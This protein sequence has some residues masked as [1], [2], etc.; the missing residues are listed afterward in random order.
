MKIEP[1]SDCPTCGFGLTWSNHL[2]YCKNPK[3]SAQ[4][5][6]KLEH[7]AKTLKIK[8]LGP[9]TI[10]KLNLYDLYDLYSLTIKSLTES[11]GSEKVATKLFNEIEHSK[12]ATANTL[13]AGFSIP[14]IGKTA[15][16]K[17]STICDTIFD[18]S[19]DN[20]KLAGLGPKATANLL[21]W[22]QSEFSWYC[23]LPFSWEFRKPIFDNKATRGNVCITGKLS[24]YKTKAEAGE[25]LCRHG[26]KVITSVSSGCTHLVNESG[27]ESAKTKKARE[28]GIEIISNLTDFLG[29]NYG[30]S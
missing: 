21:A 4:V 10:S 24:S 18:I 9:A 20:C 11:L 5:D 14:L 16:E 19:E 6:K 28:N 26:F 27:I 23:D 15:S 25:A 1:P 17:L 13:L 7:F 29:E 8:G 3:C 30:T 22:K 2:L 12:S